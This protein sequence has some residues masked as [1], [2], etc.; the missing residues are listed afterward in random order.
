MHGVMNPLP[1]VVQEIEDVQ[2][3]LQIHAYHFKQ[4]LDQREQQFKQTEQEFYNKEQEFQQREHEYQFRE[5]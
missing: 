3:S 1:G 4:E 5:L 2:T